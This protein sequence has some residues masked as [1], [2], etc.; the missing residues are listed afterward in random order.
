MLPTRLARRS[1]GEGGL[2]VSVERRP[3]RTLAAIG[4]LFA[5]AYGA[6]LVLLPKP[7]GQIVLGDALE[8]YVQ[9]RSVVFDRDLQFLNDYAGLYRVEKSQLEETVQWKSTP[10]GHMRNYMPFGPAIVW[11]PLFLTV[12]AGV[13]IARLAGAGYPL[14]GFARLFQASAGLSGVLAA[15]IGSWF[16]Y[17]AAAQLFDRR[18]AI[19]ATIAVW[20]SSSALYYSMVSPAYSHAASM[21][22]VGALWF[23]WVRALGRPDLSRYAALG[24]L[25]GFAALVR[26]QDAVL[27][28]IPCFE[29]LWY[30]RRGAIVRIAVAAAAAA[31]AFTPQMIVWWV[32]YGAPLTVPQGPGFMRWT[33][34]ALGAVLFSDNHGLFTWTPLIAL[35]VMGF[36]FVWRRA[37]LVGIAAVFTFAS[38]WYVNAAVADWWAGE[39]FGARRFVSGFPVFVLGVAAVLDRLRARPRIFLAIAA[40]FPVYTFLL[41]IQYQ[42]F[43]HRLYA[44]A[45]YPRGLFGLWLARFRVPFDLLASVLGR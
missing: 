20:L 42:A 30:H 29:A 41:L 19:W 14:D 6:S 23:V 17:R 13:W 36:V 35:A 34:P 15:T 9:L 2:L 3:G 27:L 7:N 39:A 22:A 43:M 8:H 11:A 4:L 12:T 24:A 5:L 32:L 31:L 16:A 44:G 21:F 45:P 1:L 33:E 28:A 37:P 38:A 40:L 25:A 26:W 18:A 10:T